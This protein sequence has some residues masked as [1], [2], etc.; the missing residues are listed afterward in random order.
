MRTFILAIFIALLGIVIGGGVVYYFFGQPLI[1]L[2]KMEEKV[3]ESSE[4]VLE[5]INKVYK[6]I[7]VEG[8]FA[9]IVDRKEYYGFDLPGFRK[10]ALVKIKARVSVGYD[11]DSLKIETDHTNKLIILENWPEPEILAIDADINYYDIE[12]S[13][14]NSFTPEELNL[15]YASAKDSIRAQ[16]ERSR[17]FDIAR[18]QSG[19]MFEMIAVVAEASGWQ[20]V[21]RD[22]IPATVENNPNM[23]I[24]IQTSL[25]DS[26]K[27]NNTLKQKPKKEIPI[28]S[29]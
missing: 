4:V 20:V 3:I 17:L 7:V 16:A 11:L 9:D 2:P 29:E 12:N 21:Y 13:V 23:P 27:N 1:A 5:K 15:I 10:R 8:E 24:L 19:N 6:M 18:S 22:A 25:T 28:L 14:F 26:L